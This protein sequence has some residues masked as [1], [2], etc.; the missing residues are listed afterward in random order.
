MS[1]GDLQAAGGK[2]K[3]LVLDLGHRNNFYNFSFH[4]VTGSR[5]KEGLY[6]LSFYNCYNLMPRREQPLDITVQGLQDPLAHGSPGLHQEHF[7]P[8]PQ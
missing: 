2:D 1:P 4:V 8:L 6:T 7:S 5:A 3:E